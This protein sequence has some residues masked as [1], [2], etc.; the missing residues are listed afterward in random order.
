MQ[1]N[2]TNKT[3]KIYYFCDLIFFSTKTSLPQFSHLL[4]TEFYSICSSKHWQQRNEHVC[5]IQ[6]YSHTLQQLIAFS[7]GVSTTSGMITLLST[8]TIF[9]LQ[10]KCTGVESFSAQKETFTEQNSSVHYSIPHKSLLVQTMHILMLYQCYNLITNT[11][12][13]VCIIF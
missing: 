6:V 12:F 3:R 2:K 9:N 7:F 13:K 5:L 4:S 10:I 11:Q 1:R 8:S